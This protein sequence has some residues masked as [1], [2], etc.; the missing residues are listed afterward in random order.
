MSEI[1]EYGLPQADRAPATIRL[2]EDRSR[3][4]PQELGMSGLGPRPPE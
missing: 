4:T 1:R 2:P 3:I